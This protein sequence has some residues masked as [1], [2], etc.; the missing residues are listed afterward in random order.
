MV[1]RT[2]TIAR[3]ML[4][5]LPLWAL[6]LLLGTV[7]HQPDPQTQFGAFAGYVTTDRFLM[8]H[9]VNSI[10]GAAIGSIGFVALTLH[11]S[12]TRAAGRAV[13]AMIAM[14]AG[15]A[16]ITAIFGVAAFVQPAMGRLFISGAGD[17]LALYNDVYAAPL[18]ITAMLGL[19]L[20][21]VGAVL[22]GLAIAASGRFPRWPGWLLAASIPTFAVGSTMLPV[23]ATPA[24]S[25]ALLATLTIA[26][27]GARDS[28]VCSCPL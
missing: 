27:V 25:A 17:A 4:W 12:A 22:A 8:S 10:L 7:T 20:L 18:F 14:V 16:L 2:H 23:L 19:L 13:A 9:L 5:A 28:A 24:A 21:M 3:W 26:W 15:N 11:L 1:E 6:M